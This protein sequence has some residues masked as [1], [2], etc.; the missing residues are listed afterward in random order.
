MDGRVLSC[1][2]HFWEFDITTG[3][4]L[5]DPKKKVRTYEVDVADGQVFLTA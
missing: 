5:A 3:A 4:S 2:W 1:P